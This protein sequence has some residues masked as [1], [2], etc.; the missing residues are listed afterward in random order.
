MSGIYAGGNL[1]K[2]IREGK[3]LPE[4]AAYAKDC[5]FK[6][7][8]VDTVILEIL[9]YLKLFHPD[10]FATIENDII[11]LMGL[12]FKNPSPE[13]LQGVV[14]DLY[15]DHIREQFGQSY[16]PMQA[17]IIKQIESKNCFSFSAP[18]S[19]GKS[20]VFRNL[21]QKS[22]HDIAVIVPSRAL[23]N[24]YHDRIIEAVDVK[25]VNVLT[26]V[27][28]I[29]T[30]H[31]KRNVFILTPERAREL[32]KNKSWLNIEYIL[33]DEAQL[34]DEK[35]TR[36]LYFDSI[37]RRAI[38]TFPAAKLIFAHPF[39][40]NPQAQL[41]KNSIDLDESSVSRQY[42][43]KNV[44]QVFFTYNPSTG[45]FHHF[46]TNKS[47]FGAQKLLSNNDPIEWTLKNGG[48]VLVYVAKTHILNKSVLHQ[49]EKYIALCPEIT[50]PEAVEM[51]EELRSYVGAS[52]NDKDYYNSSMLELLSH[53]IVTHHGSMPLTARLI[54]EHFT[55]KGF[56]RICFA[57]STL[58]QGIN[59]PFD[60]VYIDRFENSRTLSVKNLIGRA[61]RSTRENKFD[62]GTVIVRPNAM[63]PLRKTLQVS[64]TLSTVSHL[65][66]GEDNLDEKYSEFKKSINDGTFND[67]YNLT[68]NDV[69]KIKTDEIQAM[70]P[71]LLDMMFTNGTL[72][73]ADKITNEIKDI[74]H[75]LYE[76][77]LGR[78][79]VISEKNVLSEAIK[80]MLWKVSGRT[81][82][83][84]CQIRYARIARVNE[85][86]KH[87]ENAN[88]ITA[89]Y[90]VGYKEIPNRNLP[91]YPK[92][93]QSTLAKNVDYDLII[94]D[95]YDFLDKLIGFRLS[96][97]Y[98]AIFNEY[99]LSSND[100]RAESLAKYMKY[101]T[102]DSKEIWLLRYGFDFEDIEWLNPC[103]ESVDESE[104]SFNSKVFELDEKKSMLI[105]R[106]MYDDN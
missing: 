13:S 24:E 85:R 38:N 28:R 7:G 17:D 74:F 31:A 15:A 95:T 57:T 89:K 98:F 32:F 11:E 26:F 96:D 16:T 63:S 44:G 53:G 55:Q 91:N 48:S 30:K 83:N 27:D 5:L 82:K 3:N 36:G 73:G 76:S 101:G 47:V 69:E 8:P 67:E 92:I 10:Y 41:E 29:N 51:I 75:K 50:D 77:Y 23:I 19:T 71:T 78:K 60:V 88:S 42:K 14:F 40:S 79:L 72:I 58:E 104:I 12:F 21:I 52:K 59:M 62:I 66:E 94:Y 46:G 97:I 18:T 65:D 70:I 86:R 35:S 102:A 37:V 84:I 103:I 81:F 43:Q 61:G 90:M 39:I 100:S 4:I 45:E 20:F 9:S 25:E 68:A 1:I 64:N 34:S 2:Q 33:F 80:I 93:N 87:P 56:C 105:G 6:D 106:Y 99:F 22:N 54:L 49:F